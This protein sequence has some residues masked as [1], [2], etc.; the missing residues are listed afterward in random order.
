MD[1]LI[2]K[3]TIGETSFFRDPE[4]F[5]AI[6]EVILPEILE[7]KQ[8]SKQFRIWSAGCATGA[9]PYSLAILMARELS[10]R[11]AGWEISIHAT[12]LNRGF[13]AAAKEGKFRTWTLRSIADEVKHECF[14]QE[15]STWTIHPRY[16]RWISFR[17]M[18]LVE[19]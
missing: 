5:A 16:K 17:Q 10:D 15:G 11:I 4:Q 18:N 6:R 8:S 13:L 2:A 19:K 7:R 14:S 3:L 1:V 12:D 9:E